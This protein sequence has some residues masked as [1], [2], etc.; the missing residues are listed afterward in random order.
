MPR[1]AVVAPSSTSGASTSA[2][3]L[4]MRSVTSVD[5]LGLIRRIFMERLSR[6]EPGPCE[7]NSAGTSRQVEYSQHISLHGPAPIANGSPHPPRAGTLAHP[8]SSA[9]RPRPR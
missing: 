3:V 7:V 6:Q 2:V 4:T 5:V 9:S 1:V 8:L